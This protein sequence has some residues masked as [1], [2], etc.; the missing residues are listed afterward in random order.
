MADNRPG[1]P[2]RGGDN[3]NA[4][5][6][7]NPLA[8]GESQDGRPN[9]HGTTL[10]SLSSLINPALN[11]PQLREEN[12]G[13][14]LGS[15]DNNHS[16]TTTDLNAP[17]L[18][19]P[20]LGISS[21]GSHPGVND[22]RSPQLKQGGET[23][24]AVDS[25]TTAGN[26]PVSSLPGPGSNVEHS[27]SNCNVPASSTSNTNSYFHAPSTS[28][29]STSTSGLLKKTPLKPLIGAPGRFTTGATNRTP[30]LNI[31]LGSGLPAN[32]LEFTAAAVKQNQQGGQPPGDQQSEAAG[33]RGMS[34]EPQPHNFT[35]NRSS[36]PK[37][38]ES[39]EARERVS[40]E[41]PDNSPKKYP[42]GSEWSES[43][44]GYESKWGQQDNT[45]GS[46]YAHGQT[47][48]AQGE[49]GYSRGEENSSSWDY[50]YHRQAEAA[51]RDYKNGPESS[52][53]KRAD[54]AGWH[55]RDSRYG[56]RSSSGGWNTTDEKN[57]EGSSYRHSQKS[58]RFTV[59]SPRKSS[60][61]S[62]GRERHSSSRRRGR[63][64][65]HRYVSIM[66]SSDDSVNSGAS[67]SVSESDASE[68]VAAR[69]RRDGKSGGRSRNDR[70]SSS[71]NGKR[72]KP[73]KA[74][75]LERNSSRSASRRK[76]L[77]GRK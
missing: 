30:P 5:G 27:T 45:N 28:S 76:S 26:Q 54:D 8:P 3:V 69:S 20:Q 44:R 66:V 46:S 2:Q 16:S 11:R 21:A 34:S 57:Q 71:R 63:G 33:T 10:S 47:H 1:H 70:G 67:E 75:S 50:D 61:V 37:E 9:N 64:E 24:T 72:R 7:I 60:R 68:E 4:N 51:Y 52:Y 43:G 65:Q 62:S 55:D 32:T 29:F 6:Y 58:K 22:A 53:G 49:T 25:V 15:R 77:S 38:V 36:C 74:S 17:S 39:R 40:H 42:S 35:S 73:E 31:Q 18:N 13:L 56:R 59:T 23:S 41:N 48:G 14:A 19:A 12:L